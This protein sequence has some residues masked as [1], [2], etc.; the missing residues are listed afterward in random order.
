MLDTADQSSSSAGKYA[1][2]F[3]ILT[4]IV[5]AADG[6]MVVILILVSRKAKQTTTVTET[7]SSEN[8]NPTE[9]GNPLYTTGK[10][11]AES[12]VNERSTV[13]SRIIGGVFPTSMGM[14]VWGYGSP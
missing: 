8:K 3:I 11:E 14:G 7:T 1:A 10:T 13:L 2:V 6:A 5:L 12:K 9:I 4:V